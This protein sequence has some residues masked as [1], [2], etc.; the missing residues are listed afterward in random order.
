MN[1]TIRWLA[2]EYFA[3][4]TM[5]TATFIDGCKTMLMMYA[6][7]I[8]Q[9]GQNLLSSH[10]TPRFLYEASE[11]IQ[12]YH[13]AILFQLT[14]PGA[15]SIYY[16]DE[17]GMSGGHDPDNRRAF[18][19]NDRSSWDMETHTLVRSLIALRKT[20]PALKKGDWEIVWFSEEA[21]AYRRF[22]GQTRVL[23]VISREATIENA[24]I[25]IETENPELLFGTTKFKKV[26]K[27]IEIT[28]QGPWSGAIFTI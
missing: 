12:R 16:G 18:P 14:M 19:W 1:Y 6:S 25:P 26:E 7:A 17:I 11:D 3:K 4:A 28:Y 2:L 9:V 5:D 15:P 27:G 8:T 13:L 24:L 23:V 21:F 10:D 20:T 22:D